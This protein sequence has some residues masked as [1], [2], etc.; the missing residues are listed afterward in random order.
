LLSGVVAWCDYP[1]FIFQ[2]VLVNKKMDSRRFTL[3]LLDDPEVSQPV[4]VISF[5]QVAY[6]CQPV[7]LTIG[8]IR[9]LAELLG[10]W[11]QKVKEIKTECFSCNPS[12]GDEA[13]VSVA[14]IS[15][16]RV[17]YAHIPPF[18]L[19]T[20]EVA[21]LKTLLERWME[22]LQKIQEPAP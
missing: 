2:E 7:C 13:G 6:Y 18:I 5:R 20:P 14:I 22:G 21:E 16:H 8:E 11:N 17:Q 4:T 1:V 9:D 12:P 15:L 19:T 10:S 3:E